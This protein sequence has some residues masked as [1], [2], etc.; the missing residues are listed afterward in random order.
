MIS[1]D[2]TT[3]AAYDLAGTPDL[4][5]Q[6]VLTALGSSVSVVVYDGSNVVK[7]SG[8]MANPWAT[9]VLNVLTVGQFTAPLN[10]TA[11][12]TPD[13]NWY[14]R[15]EG[16]G[17]WLRGSFGLLNSGQDF[18]WSLST[19]TSGQTGTIG[20]TTISAPRNT[21]QANLT[22]SYSLAG[23]ALTFGW[24][25][26][27]TVDLGQFTAGQAGTS[28]LSTYG[29][30]ATGTPLYTLQ[31]GAPSGATVGQS[32]GVLNRP[33]LPAGSYFV[34]VDLS[35]S[36]GQ[37]TNLSIT[38]TTSSTVTMAWAVVSGATSYK[39]E[40]SAG[41]AGAWAQVAVKTTNS[42][43]DS[44]LTASTAYSY[45]VRASNG[46]VDGPYSNT[47]STTTS[48][49]SASQADWIARST[50]PGVVWSHDFR[51]QNEIDA[52]QLDG[53]AGG[54]AF[55]T[56]QGMM[57]QVTDPVTGFAMSILAL[58][59][60]TAQ[61]FPATLPAT[62]PQTLVL[63]DTTYWPTDCYVRLQHSTAD[64][65]DQY[66]ASIPNSGSNLYH[67][68]AV[69]GNTLTLTYVPVA[70]G[71]N[72]VNP[73][74]LQFPAGSYIGAQAKSWKRPFSALRAAYNGKG[75]DDIA[76]AGILR[77][78][79]VP[80]NSN[81]IWGYG[82]YGHPDYIA[83]YPTWAPPANPAGSTVTPRTNFWDGSE[84][85]LQ[86]RM[87][88]DP[89]FW[90]LHVYANPATA[91][92]RTWGRKLWFLQ[93]DNSSFQQ[94]LGNMS[95]SNKYQIPATNPSPFFMGKSSPTGNLGSNNCCEPEQ[96][97][98][99]AMFQPGSQWATT[100]S[101]AN[102]ATAAWEY[103]AGEWLTFLL[104]VRPGHHNVG[105]TFLEMKV[106]R[107]GETSY[108]TVFSSS[109]QVI[110]YNVELHQTNPNITADAFYGYNGFWPA[111]YL[112][113]ELGNLVP[114]AAY[115]VRWA[116]MIMSQQPIPVP[117]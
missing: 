3:R 9:R 73:T 58:G 68:T 24:Y 27:T 6:A 12:G 10:V 50:G 37:V 4:K 49:T 89:R 46:T 80:A 38:N 2:A 5:A 105:D 62:A 42:F 15:F 55:G 33:S 85:Y 43:A 65:R 16:A 52:F 17:R 26:L 7:G 47:A 108:T 82:Y 60:T 110:P 116:Q 40:R 59:G 109:T 88:I 76:R 90:N 94:I 45:R 97:A 63:E 19:W 57:T 44:G 100:T 98:I 51:T 107:E 30:T 21:A 92:E 39:V 104:H 113:T 106:A 87:K 31:A 54:I 29:Y 32:T 114:K 75:V 35:P 101:V 78:R 64:E 1:L 74:Q 91:T 79:I 25:D 112:N 20:T 14:L 111:G 67:V 23:A 102:G 93:T 34:D 84:F 71:F 69:S 86:F 53:Q 95:P 115:Y 70:G 66:S 117:T 83:A 13:A 81:G 8:T 36:I 56:T 11:S 61:V 41:T 48:P 28:D 103:S 99:N 18:T 77:D 72:N 22:A 96:P